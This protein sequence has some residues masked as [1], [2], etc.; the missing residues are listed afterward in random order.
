MRNILLILVIM[1]LCF[2]VALPASASTHFYASFSGAGSQD[3]S[4]CANAVN[5]AFTLSTS[6]WGN[7]GGKIGGPDS[8]LTLCGTW[9]FPYVGSGND[10]LIIWTNQTGASGTSGHPFT[11]TFKDGSNYAVLT[12]PAFNIAMNIAGGSSWVVID[13]GVPC[14]PDTA[15]STNDTGTGIIQNTDNG[16]GMTHDT[17]DSH[18]ILSTTSSCT[19]CEIKNLLGRNGYVH[20]QGDD[21]HLGGG[22]CVFTQN[23]QGFLLVHDLTCH[24]TEN[25]LFLSGPDNIDDGSVEVYNYAGYHLS[26]GIGCG[27]AQLSGGF[28]WHD[29]HIYDLYPFDTP[30][31]T[32]HKNGIHCYYVP[33][34]I[35]TP[36]LISYL[37][38][39]NVR[40]D[41]N[42]GN[43]C[44]TA[45]IFCEGGT[46]YCMNST[47]HYYI[48]NN[49]FAFTGTTAGIPNSM[50]ILA[51]GA[52][53]IYNNTII[54]NGAGTQGCFGGMDQAPTV[55]NNVMQGCS[56]YVGAASAPGIGT[57]SNNFYGQVSSGNHPWSIAGTTADTFAAWQS[58]CSCD[59][60]PSQAQL[61]SNW[62]NLSTSTGA[63][64]AGFVGISNGTNLTS[65]ATGNLAS[66]TKDIAGTSRTG[67][68]W[69]A[70]AYTFGSPP[71]P[72]P[73]TLL[74]LNS[75][76]SP[77]SGTVG[78]PY[79]YNFTASGGIPPYSFGGSGFP[80][81]LLLSASGA[82]S[83]L[84]TTAGSNSLSIQ[85]S[86]SGVP[87]QI[88]GSVF[89]LT[90]NAAPLPPPPVVTGI[91]GPQGPAGTLTIGT[92]TTGAPGTAAK[93]TNSGTSTNA[94]L[95]FVIPQGTAGAP[96]LITVLTCTRN[97][98]GTYTCK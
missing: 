86:D 40:F 34:S 31:D 9:S 77:P 19:N 92:V 94:I 5:W 17:V 78:T 6:N 98:N 50:T 39:Y 95:N 24:D 29:S 51:G 73:V 53:Q 55:K 65:I 16:S 45:P 79:L 93:V 32:Y 42:W 11:V 1:A 33:A 7:A 60:T 38:I 76:P 89:P 56:W 23:T 22:D 74:S 84:P 75:S 72:P 87:K 63:I 52:A 71:G 69:T 26:W 25:G 82:L 91:P 28:K 18:F 70:G 2:A 85:V 36:G 66:L 13:G 20:T 15:C 59:A 67:S 96:G 47:G 58:A 27:Y 68:S 97:S 41:G 8:I 37:T 12:S 14:G 88:S 80:S 35:S 83:G 10:A 4:S 62:G 3:G 30:S 21:T 64:S 54:G 48:F 43:C 61:G 90:I 57:W 49:V 81:G 46:A 44:I